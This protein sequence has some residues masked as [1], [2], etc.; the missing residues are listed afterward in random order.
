MIRSKLI[1]DDHI[2]MLKINLSSIFFVIFHEK[3]FQN[4][5]YIY[6]YVYKIIQFNHIILLFRENKIKK[7]S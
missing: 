2:S 3:Q 1:D 6:M 5:K 4:F 7:S